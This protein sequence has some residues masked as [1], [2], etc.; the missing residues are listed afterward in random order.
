M[1]TIGQLEVAEIGHF[2]QSKVARIGNFKQP[3]VA[4]IGNPKLSSSV[5]LS[6]LTNGALNY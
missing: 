1:P 3:R 4:K 2:R 6:N 5:T